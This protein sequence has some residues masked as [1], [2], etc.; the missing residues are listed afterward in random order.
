MSRVRTVTSMVQGIVKTYDLAIAS[1][2]K[3]HEEALAAAYLARDEVNQAAEKAS[4]TPWDDLIETANVE[5]SEKVHEANVAQAMA[6]VE[7]NKAHEEALAAAYLARD[8]VNQAAEQAATISWGDI[9]SVALAECAAAVATADRAQEAAIEDAAQARDDAIGNV[10]R[11]LAA[12]SL[13]SRLLGKPGV[14]VRRL[15]G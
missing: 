2:D 4:Q 8:E 15:S 9:I 6:M 7:V 14:W 13:S 12:A 10:N 5:C 1:T 3:A 11:E